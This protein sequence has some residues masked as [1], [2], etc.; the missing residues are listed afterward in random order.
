MRN[1]GTKAY[2]RPTRT[3]TATQSSVKIVLKYD[4]D[5]LSSIIDKCIFATDSAME[6]K[7]STVEMS[8]VI[9]GDL[10]CEGKMLKEGTTYYFQAETSNAVGTTKSEIIAV[11]TTKTPGISVNS[12][13][14]Y[15]NSPKVKI[16]L[17]LPD[18]TTSFVLSNDGGFVKGTTFTTS[19][20][21]VDWTL[22]TN[23][24]EK[25]PKTVYVRFIK[26]E[27]DAVTLTDDIILD[28]TAPALTAATATSS[29]ASQG[30]VSV[31][32]VRAKSKG[33]VKLLVKASDANS[34][35]GSIEVRTSSRGRAT[36]IK[37]ANP[38]AKSQT[39]NLKTTS[40]SIQVRVI[41][42]AGN[43]SKWKDVKVR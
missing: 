2:F 31:L 37:Y 28:T 14:L 17:T 1:S 35:I 25:L 38:T 11:S 3:I 8:N 36:T 39:V 24:S 34:G 22:A 4:S 12:G 5:G 13:D 41:D 26:A 21:T 30:A 15:T 7:V 40:K 16:G 10:T 9:N 18:G 23:G 6:Q 33:G 43:S 42:R 19:L 29:S 20:T 27:G 32:S